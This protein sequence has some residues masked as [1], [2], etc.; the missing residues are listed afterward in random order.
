[1]LLYSCEGMHSSNDIEDRYSI[2][3]EELHSKYANIQRVRNDILIDED[4]VAEI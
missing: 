3:K 2:Y 1:M 4:P